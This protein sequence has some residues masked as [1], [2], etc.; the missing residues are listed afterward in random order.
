MASIFIDYDDVGLN[1]LNGM[2]K[3]DSE[4][5]MR[6]FFTDDSEPVPMRKCM[7]IR[8]LE[9]TIIPEPIEIKEDSEHGFEYRFAATLGEA[10]GQDPNEKYLVV[11]D[12]RNYKEMFEYFD[13]Q[14]VFMK[15]APDILSGIDLVHEDEEPVEEE[16]DEEE[17]AEEEPVEEEPVE[18][19]PVEEEP[20]E[21]EPVE[22][23]PEDTPYYDPFDNGVIPGN[24]VVAEDTEEA[25]E[26][27]NEAN[28]TTIVDKNVAINGNVNDNN[29]YSA[30]EYVDETGNNI[31]TDYKTVIG[32]GIEEAE[33]ETAEPE[34]EEPEEIKK[35]IK[36][37]KFTGML[38]YLQAQKMTKIVE[39]S[40]NLDEVKEKLVE[41]YGKQKA[42][43]LFNTVYK[44]IEHL[45]D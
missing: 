34:A 40:T 25:N 29:T 35:V 37:P 3:V 12:K 17:P 31:N 19:E 30:F 27:E 2:Q 38:Q 43:R 45:Y 36:A 32:N 21:E 41:E 20:V 14:D 9:A 13:K 42:E 44:K 8:E 1:G 23:E 16:P 4:D 33:P 6:I 22:E 15:N 26:D 7:E 24:D 28:E 39:S 10:V 18:E 5:T 11:S